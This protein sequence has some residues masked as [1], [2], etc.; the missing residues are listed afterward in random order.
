MAFLA[1]FRSPIIPYALLTY[2]LHVRTQ[3]RKI[4]AFPITQ[5]TL[6]QTSLC[7]LGSHGHDVLIPSLFDDEGHLLWTDPLQEYGAEL[8]TRVRWYKQS[9][10]HAR[11]YDTGR[12]LVKIF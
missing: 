11:H 8:H 5:A 3:T 10:A 4:R 12:Q 1:S 2:T 7:L 9:Y 6:I